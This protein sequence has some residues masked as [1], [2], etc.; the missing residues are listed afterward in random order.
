MRQPLR[1][2]APAPA[3]LTRGR[4]H[5]GAR[6]V[7][8]RA[9]RR[10]RGPA[11]RARHRLARRRVRAARPASTPTL[12]AAALTQAALRRQ[13]RAKFGAGRRG[14]CFTRAGL[15]QATRGRRGAPPG[16]ALAAARVPPRSPTSAAASAPT[17]SPSPGPACACWRSTPIPAPPRSPRQRPGT[18][19]GRRSTWPLWTPPRSICPMWTLCSATRPGATPRAAGACSTRP[20]SRRRGPSSPAWPA[21]VPRTVLKLAPGIDHALHARPAPRR[22]W[23]SVDGDV[24][25]AAALVRPARPGPPPRHRAAPRRDRRRRAH[26]AGHATAPVGPVGRYVYDPDGAVVRVPP[27]RRVRRHGR[28]YAGRPDR[29]PTSSP[30]RRRPPRSAAASSPRRS[31]R[32]GVKRLR[33]ALRAADIGRWRSANAAVGLDAGPAAP[34]PAAVRPRVGDPAAHPV[35]TRPTALLAARVADRGGQNG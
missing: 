5:G 27:G 33:A 1:F 23:V 13:A 26:R 6:C 16:G 8:P 30:T 35:G 3:S 15:E 29:S 19:P 17:P 25:E 31:C 34:G 21:R 32:S 9:P 28:R 20:R 12:A 14:C 7:R 24:V 11:T 22:E 4:R 2:P 18:G 10:S